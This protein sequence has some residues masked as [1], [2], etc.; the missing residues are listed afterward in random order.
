MDLFGGRAMAFT[1][2]GLSLRMLVFSGKKIESWYSVPLNPNLLRD[3]LVAA[4]D[5]VGE[6]MAEVIKGKG[7]PSSGVLCALPSAGSTS[8]TLTLPQLSKGKLEDV[9]QREIKRL[10]PGSADT[11]YI[12]WQQLPAVS[13]A[14]KQAVYALAIPRNNVVNMVEICRTAGVKIKG[15]ELKPFALTRAVNCKTG[16]IVH[17]EI[18][19]IEIVIVDKSFPA[20]FRNI[21]VKDAKPGPDIACQNLL[22]ELPFTIDYYNRSHPDSN[23]TTDTAIYMSGELALDPQV[24]VKV[25]EA[26]GRTVTDVEPQVQCPP[27][28][29]LAQYIV[30][31]GLM[32][33]EKW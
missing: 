8:Q 28:F 24:A 10:I 5:K 15:I 18:D 7:T 27:N 17:C 14:K 16:I 29:P 1:I 25:S 6:V 26:S 33:R 22:R 11:D 21:P 3:G 19:S 30:N 9:V 2:E 23:V 32:L 20:L 31:I 12:Y 13:A 4:P